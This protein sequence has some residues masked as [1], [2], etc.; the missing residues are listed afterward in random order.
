[1]AG[2]CLQ[3]LHGDTMHQSAISNMRTMCGWSTDA[4][5]CG[6]RY[7]AAVWSSIACEPSHA[8]AKATGAT[9]QRTL[10]I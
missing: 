7:S 3:R 9:E 10:A 4:R 8:C 5:L 1:M 2:Q 6:D